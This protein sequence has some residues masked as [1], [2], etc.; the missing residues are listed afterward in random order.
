MSKQPDSVSINKNHYGNSLPYFIG[1]K[2]NEN[3]YPSKSIEDLPY[4]TKMGKFQRNNGI[5]FLQR[6]WISFRS[7]QFICSL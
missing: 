4:K 2:E 7:L 6:P 3:I 1:H 5:Y